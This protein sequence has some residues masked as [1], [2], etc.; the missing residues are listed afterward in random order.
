M[1]TEQVA[2]TPKKQKFFTKDLVKCVVVLA[3]IALV[4]G[5]LLGVMNW[6][7]YVDPDESIMKDV[8]SFFGTDVSGISKSEDRVLDDYV[9]SCF[10]AKDAEGNEL[11]YCY[12]TT[13]N[14]AKDGTIEMLIYISVNGVIEDVVV[15]DQGETAGYFSKVEKANKSK[16]VGLD[17]DEID[18]VTF[19]KKTP[20]SDLGAG[21]VVALSGATYTSTGYHN[22]VAA[23]VRAYKA[24]AKEV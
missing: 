5:I 18:G 19:Y 17:L 23:A 3:T 12:Y 14:G 16:Y 2:T 22:A 20:S 21:D 8:A 4:A 11:G 9:N 24:Y 1:M 6:V 7:T 15:Y 13:G 10:V